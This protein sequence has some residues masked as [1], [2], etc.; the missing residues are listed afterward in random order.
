MEFIVTTR[1]GRQFLKDQYLYNKNETGDN[2]NSY[3]GCME[4]RSSNGCG[5]RITLDH[6]E[7]FLNQIGQHT[8]PPN[9]E[10]IAVKK[11]R[12][13]MKRDATNVNLTTNNII[14]AN[15]AEATKAVLAKIP[16]L[17]TVHR[18]VRKQR[19]VAIG[20][21]PIPETTQFEIVPPFNVSNTREQFI[22][23]DNGRQ[24]RIIIFATRQSLLFLQNREDWFMDGAFSTVPPQFFQ[25]YTIH[26]LHR[27]RNVVGAYCLLRNK[28]QETYVEVLRQLQHLTNNAVSHSIMIDFEQGMIA[29]LCQEYPL[30]PR[31]SCLF[32]L[33]KSIYRHVQELGLSQHFMNDEQFWTNIRMVGALSFV[34]IEDTV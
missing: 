17:E 13:N 6:D 29:A 20:Y 10:L 4:R 25:L 14:S 28:R 33:S 26:G 30:L 31:K 3:W 19:A 24:D 21:T 23:Y 7:V 2:S 15:T 34:P 1:G 27:S 11:I 32:Y 12:T 5:V 18:D 8:H 9:P 22:Y 16:K